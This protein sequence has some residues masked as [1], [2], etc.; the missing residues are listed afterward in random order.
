[1]APQINA[2]RSGAE[3]VVACPGRLLDLMRQG[4]VDLSHVEVLVLDE[5]DR[6]F[7]MG[8]LPDVR[9]IVAAVPARR[10]TLLFSAT[11]P[12]DI[13]GLADELGF[14]TRTAALAMGPS[15]STTLPDRRSPAG[16]VVGAGVGAPC[17][18]SGPPKP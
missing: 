6:M 11:M 5:G 17:A 12:A 13:R 15:A 8:F 9:R 3:I 2:L 16:F 7:D 4:Y 18:P 1:M 14:C 10:Q